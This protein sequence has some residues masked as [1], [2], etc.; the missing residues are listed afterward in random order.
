MKKKLVS[1]KAFMPSKKFGSYC[2]GRV[3]IIADWIGVRSVFL[4]SGIV[5][6]IVT[7]IILKKQAIICMNYRNKMNGPFRI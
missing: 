4:R 1:A 3:A 7:F 2:K 5:L 6:L